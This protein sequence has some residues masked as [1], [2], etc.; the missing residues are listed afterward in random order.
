MAMTY[1]HVYVAKIAFGAKDQQTLKVFLEAE[2]FDGPALIIAY[3]HCIAHGI[4]MEAPLQHQKALIDSGQWVLYRYNPDLVK[5]GKN[6]LT[7]DSQPKKMTVEEYM[8]LENRFKML[9]K[10]HP[11]DA[12][13]YYEQAKHE[14]KVQYEQLQ[15]LASRSF[16]G[17]GE[18]KQEPAQPVTQK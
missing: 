7:L 13:K 12:R 15:Y 17:N 4:N 14:A 6:P 5:E 18:T 9:T 16:S 8:N 11:E 1:G 10:T 2:Q 3:S